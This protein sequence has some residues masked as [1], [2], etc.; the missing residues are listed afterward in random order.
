MRRLFAAALLLCCLTASAA[1][2]VIRMEDAGLTYD[3]PDSW[4]IL[5]P[6]RC[7]IYSPILEEMGIDAGSLSEEMENEGIQSRGMPESGEQYVQVMTRSDELSQDIFDMANATD[8]Q[9][10]KIRNSAENNG[11]WEHT[12]LRTQDAEWQ[13]EGGRYWLYVN[14]TE[15]RGSDVVSRGLRY[16]TIHNGMYVILD[17][18]LTGRRFTNRDVSSFRKRIASLT[19]TKELPMP[20]RSVEVSC[21]IPS[22][23][24]DSEGEI[25]GTATAGANLTLTA[26]D[27]KGNRED[28]GACTAD[29]KGRFSFAYSLPREG[30]WTF[31]L[32]AEAEDRDTNVT[33]TEVTYSESAI[34]CS[35]IEETMTT[36]TDKT[37]VSGKTLAGASLQLVTPAG[38]RKQRAG[39]DGSFSFEIRTKETG[40]ISCTLII[41]KN[42]YTQRRI[43]FSI[44]RELTD[45]QEKEKVRASAVRISYGSLTRDL[46]KNR[47]KILNLTG[48]VTQVS[49]AGATTYVR[50]M[51]TKDDKG[52][53]SNP[54][55]LVT[56]S[57]ISVKEN[58]LLTCTVQVEGVD[59]EQDS[60]GNEISVP[61]LRILFVD[62]VE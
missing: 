4:L 3:Y 13:T 36:Q 59:E 1:A 5:S 23:V 57:A 54:V 40:T 53:W 37:I 43:H 46:A 2:Q 33:T 44:T 58:D 17:W 42:S 60:K 29:S 16:T 12:G 41:D 15:M 56:D 50:M 18:R 35:G 31:T 55:I 26:D 49:S 24:S 34:P 38:V 25:R 30:T 6:Q 28:F 45:D 22:E 20:R 8:D 27:G 52:Q 11:L 19:F 48:Y 14:Y 21:T 7:M 62:K 47:E 9:R 32:T 39:K 10:R 51:Y 61:R